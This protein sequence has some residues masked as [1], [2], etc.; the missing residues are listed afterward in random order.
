MRIAALVRQHVALRTLPRWLLLTTVTSLLMEGV[1]A[2][3]G[4]HPAAAFASRLL[5]AAVL[6]LPLTVFLLATAFKPRCGEW[7]LALPL[8]ARRLRRAHLAAFALAGAAVLGLAAL[9]AAVHDLVLLRHAPAT[10]PG[11]RGGD[12]ARRAVACLL[13]AVACLAA[14]SPARQRVEASPAK[15]PGASP[16]RPAPSWRPRP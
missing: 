5:A 10:P 13:C 4:Q 2:T 12:P 16:W 8:P 6:W 15:W 14:R 1:R 11:R 9:A 7:H 3:S